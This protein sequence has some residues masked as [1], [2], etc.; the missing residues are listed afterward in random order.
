MSGRLEALEARRRALLNKCE[1]QRLE[2]AY[3]IAQIRPAEQLTAWTRRSATGRRQS[4]LTW[5]AGV[6][7]LLLMLRR[8]RVLSGVGW[9]AG[10]VALASR[11]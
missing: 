8:R 11:A 6:V 4:P 5:I 7:G 1:E 3:R 9:L 2:L 10:L